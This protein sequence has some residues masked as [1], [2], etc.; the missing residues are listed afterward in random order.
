MHIMGTP[1]LAIFHPNIR[2]IGFRKHPKTDMLEA[3][4]AEETSKI[5]E[6]TGLR[7]LTIP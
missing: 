6:L 1:T 3:L 2:Q 7:K 4:K 5:E